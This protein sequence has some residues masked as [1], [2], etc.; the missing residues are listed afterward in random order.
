MD[1]VL[2][3][4]S[5]GTKTLAAVADRTGRIVARVQAPGLDPLALPDWPDH[6]S[7][8]I[9]D[10]GIP[11][12]DTAAA[13]LGLP[14]HGEVPAI[15]E[16][17][18]RVADVI[19]PGRSLVQN[20]VRIAFDGAFAMGGG[21]LILAGTGSMAWASRGGPDAPHIRVGGWSE[22]FGD[23]GSAYWIGR[24][25][26]SLASQELDGRRV[27]TGFSTGI[28]A[29]IGT[30]A[31]GLSDWVASHPQ[32]RAA[33]AALSRRVADLDSAGDATARDLLHSAAD[34]LALTL[35]AA[36]RRAADA[37]LPWSHAGSVLTN[38]TIRQRITH[39]LGRDPQPPRLP[40]VGGALLRAAHLA[41]WQ[42]DD[43]W[44]QTL[45]RALG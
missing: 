43:D 30:G 38:A 4:D 14:F 3:L 35:Q 10:L 15:T 34:A 7:R 44:T 40:P 5:G 26:L 11:T 22:V 12:A 25:A 28:L 1:L 20:D 24:E 27:E 41:G 17:Q 2:G 45:A 16:Q 21:G 31:D 8:L 23:E 32:P 33:I 29:A 13:V 36:L 19:F 37:D 39:R 42:G 6:L 9:A 18:I